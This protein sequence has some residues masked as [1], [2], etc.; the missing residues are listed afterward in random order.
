MKRVLFIAYKN[1]HLDPRII[2]ERNALMA[3]GYH[4]D[5]ICLPPIFDVS[6]IINPAC[7]S[8]HCLPI[9]K[10]R[11]RKLRYLFEYAAFFSYAFFKCT[12]LFIKHRYRLIQVFVMPE[13][14][15]FTA[16]I[17]WLFGA[18]ILMDWEDP[19]IEVYKSKFR[20]NYDWIFIAVIRMLE[21]LSTLFSHHII[22]PNIGFKR[23]FAARG[24]PDSKI[25]IVMNAPDQD[26]FDAPRQSE[27]VLPITRPFTLLFNGSNLR[28]HGTDLIIRALALIPEVRKHTQVYILDSK[29]SDYAHECHE[30]VDELGVADSIYFYDSLPNDQM[31]QFIS[32]VSAGIVPNRDTPFTRINFPQRI[33]EFAYFRKPVIASRL[34]GIEDY[35]PDDS[36]VYFTPENVPELAEKIR[37]LF[38]NEQARQAIGERGHD[39]CSTLEWKETYLANVRRLYGDR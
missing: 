23:M 16:L 17:P 26:I 28:R 9:M 15:V 34:R 33:M 19:S 24:I 29:L 30:L 31:A 36:I 22:T 6:S 35:M 2:R 11:G 5:H 14:L 1:Y 10:K 3:D 37:F 39:V 18:K 25:D 32:Q 7:E 8:L 12:T 13:A 27:P 38:Q 20:S 4:V 21:K